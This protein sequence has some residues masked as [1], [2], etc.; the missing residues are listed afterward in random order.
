MRRIRRLLALCLLPAAALACS[1][2]ES[3][4][5]G[6]VG[7]APEYDFTPLTDSIQGVLDTLPRTDRAALMLIQRGHVIYERGFGG[8]S[9]D[10]TLPIA[11]SSKLLTAATVLALV[12]RGVLGL[13]VPIERYL[14]TMQD[15]FWRDPRTHEITPRQLLS[16]TA[17][18]GIQHPCIYR[19]RASL[20]ECAVAIG[21]HGL[22]G[23]PGTV[24]S[25]GQSTFH[26]AGAV[27]ED[28]T[29]RSW[30]ENLQRFLTDPLDM[31]QTRYR[32]DENPQLGDGAVSTV[33][34]FSHLM[35]MIHD[36]GVHRGRRV[37]S[38]G[39]VREMKENQTDG[40]PI[41][42]TPRAPGMRYGLGIWREEVSESGEPVILSAPGSLGFWPW[43]D[44][45]R[46]LVGVLA[47]PPHL[48]ISG[49]IVPIV[50]STVEEIVPP[51]R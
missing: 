23:D 1:E 39:L 40:L 3:L 42:F 12:D 48:S 13:D 27:V 43:I 34:E 25:Y 22:V 16:L 36:G 7:P 11:S 35:R 45:E 5:S 33:R 31:P 14:E 19:P 6:P 28:A 37:L 38:A 46:D 30:A 47:V 15:G 10:D 18:F 32:G 26:V 50:L 44:L 4:P 51:N 49:S 29:E 21:T 24:M 2:G 9:V 41:A 20:Q 8:L 17:G